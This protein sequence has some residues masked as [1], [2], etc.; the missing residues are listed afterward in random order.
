MVLK[1]YQSGFLNRTANLA[2]NE[3]TL[4]SFLQ[5]VPV[6][7]NWFTV[8]QW[9]ETVEIIM[10]IVRSQE[11]ALKLSLG[12]LL[13][14]NDDVMMTCQLENNRMT[15]PSTNDPWWQQLTALMRWNYHFMGKSLMEVERYAAIEAKETGYSVG[16]TFPEM[17][18]EVF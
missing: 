1:N 18:G 16:K 9:K 12:K 13:Q 3:F 7:T 17:R 6:S 5:R 11:K 8:Q 2:W 4:I 14:R 10:M 15:D